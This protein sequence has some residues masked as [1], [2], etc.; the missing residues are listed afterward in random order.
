LPNAGIRQTSVSAPV[1]EL[2]HRPVVDARLHVE[3]PRRAVGL[4]HGDALLHLRPDE[5]V[6]VGQPPEVGA[7][8]L[9]GVQQ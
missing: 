4:E 3:R 7:V 6:E 2:G 9:E 1:G 5:P 8:R